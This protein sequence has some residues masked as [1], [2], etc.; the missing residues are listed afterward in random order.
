[1]SD[2]RAGNGGARAGAGRKRKDVKHE[3]A[4]A[5]AEN[6]I[7]DRLPHI[8]D[9]MFYLAMGGYERVEEQYAPAGSLYIGSGEFVE[10]MYP[11]KP[12]DELVLIKRTVSIADKDRAAN[13]YLIDRIMGKPTQQTELTGE[14]SIVKGYTT[15]ANPDDWDEPGPGTT[16]E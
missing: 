15:E 2:G 3:T 12:R 9:N 13:V 11:D 5:Q 8:I 10:R 7:V 4:I 16:P 6:R 1:M 14:L